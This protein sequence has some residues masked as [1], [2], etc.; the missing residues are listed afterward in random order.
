MYM[1]VQ[2]YIHDAKRH[3]V[4]MEKQGIKACIQFFC[5]LYRKSN[6]GETTEEKVPM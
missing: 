1:L 4:V 3:V 5:S 2:Q 6:L